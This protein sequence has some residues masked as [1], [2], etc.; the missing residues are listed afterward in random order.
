VAEHYLN[1]KRQ[2]W[3]EYVTQV[4]QWELDQY[5]TKY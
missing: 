4:S 5:L 3:R 2:E 1:A